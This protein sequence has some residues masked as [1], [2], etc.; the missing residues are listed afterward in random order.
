MSRNHTGTST[1]VLPDFIIVG[2][3]KGGTI[4]LWENLNR[5][6]GVYLPIDRES[7]TPREIHFFDD[8]WERGLDWYRAR[9]DRPEL[10]QGEKTPA[11]MADRQ[12]HARM[13][14]S[15]PDAKLLFL[16][17][18]PCQRAYS[19][20]NMMRQLPAD[21]WNHTD[22]E[23]EAALQKIPKLIERGRYIEH[24]ESLL[25]HYPRSQCHFVVSERLRDDPEREMQ[26]ILDFLRVQA[27]SGDWRRYH[28]RPYVEPMNSETRL[29]V[30]DFYAPLNRRLFEF[31]GEE[32]EEWQPPA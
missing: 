26:D 25:M 13:G 28:E 1:G 14:E 16:L 24:I 23:F 10:V 5:H 15:V 19:S 7:A 8:N 31:L 2:A 12:V 6:P 17:R 18:E 22:L 9:F 3:E 21:H 30:M 11:Y 27:F 29:R 20:W 4:A 32:I